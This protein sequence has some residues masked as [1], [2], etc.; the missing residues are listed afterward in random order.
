MRAMNTTIKTTA[1]E[2]KFLNRVYSDSVPF[3]KENS[4]VS[5]AARFLEEGLLE[6]SAVYQMTTGQIPDLWEV[7]FALL[8]TFDKT[9][10]PFNAMQF[11]P[12]LQHME[13]LDE[14]Q[15]KRFMKNR[16][17]RH[18]LVSNE[19]FEVVLNLWKPGRVSDIHGH[20]DGGCLFKLL[21]GK[22]EEVRYTP[23]KKPRLMSMS[24]LRKESIAYI[25]DRIAYH[26]VRNPYGSTAISLHVYLK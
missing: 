17:N 13:D 4:N 10:A 15:V 24:S 23:E 12:A 7:C 21:H 20:P 3:R 2:L 6:S 1:N 19:I 22:L 5:L 18:V 14:Q 26:Q 16:E 9:D 11:L 8:K 25:D